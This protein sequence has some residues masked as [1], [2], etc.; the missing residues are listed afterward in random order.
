M[1]FQFTEKQERFRQEIR[2]FL[3]KELPPGWVEGGLALDDEEEDG[4]DAK[5]SFAQALAKKMAQ[6]RWITA[7]WPKE[8]G[9]LGWTPLEQLIFAEEMTRHKVPRPY[10]T[11]AGVS[12]VGPTIAVHGTEEQKARW[13]PGIAGAEERWCQ[14]FSEPNAGSDLAGLETTAREDGDEF[15]VNGTKIWSS[16]A[17]K[18]KWG[19]LLCRTDPEAPKHRGI[20]YLVVDMKSPGIT[21]APIINICDVYSF[22]QVFLDDVRVPKANLIGEKNRGWYSGTTTLNLERSFIRHALISQLYFD[23]FVATLKDGFNGYRP[24]EGNPV[25]RHKLADMAV[26]LRVAR[27]LA[28]RVAWLQSQGEPPSYESSVSKLYCGEMAQRLSQLV[29]ETLGQYGQ[30]KKG[31]K[32]AVQHGKAQQ[33]YLTQRGITIGGG[34]SEIQRSLIARRGLGLGG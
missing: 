2:D 4:H 13:L 14:L 29:M 26:E 9:G 27:L 6:R 16:G 32:H 34:T 21:F 17:H 1:E 22:N 7:R 28:Y 20:S 24:L 25:L 19:A 10:I 33:I 31:S 15:V 23:E 8:Y 30:V 11:D 3:S 12:N 5:D 18:A